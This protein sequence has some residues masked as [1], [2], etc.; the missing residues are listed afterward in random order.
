MTDTDSSP[1]DAATDPL[2]QLIRAAGRRPSPSAA[3]YERV[4]LAA[5]LAWQMKVHS[6]RRRRLAWW[7][8]AASVA[9]AGVA[10]LTTLPWAPPAPVAELAM[11]RGPVER[12]AVDQAR[13]EPVAR[14]AKIAAGDRLRTAPDGG[15]V[16][17]VAG[18]VAIRVRGGTDCT[19]DDSMRVTLGGGTL[20]VD[21]GAGGAGAALEITTPHGVVRHVG[22]QYEVRAL[23]TE[24]R[25]RVR[26][27]RVRLDAGAATPH[28]T[29]AGEEL[30]VA[31]GGAVERRPIATDSD[32]WRW[33]EAL[34]PAI[35]LDGGSA[36]DALQWVARETGKRLV[37][38]D[39]NVELLARNAVIRGSSAGL[40][41]MQILEVVM[42]TSAGLDYRIGEGTLIIRR[43]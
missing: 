14:G 15:A 21:T 19:F 1:T 42:A 39:S 32:E 25:V 26:E 31:A 36:F 16:F 43:R 7:A 2:G 22:T 13:W 9:T 29:V 37:F 5:H 17:T 28:E 4:R 12:F 38:E 6:Q 3:E 24:L 33:A 10:V 40:E 35:E 11:L 34:A 27:G 8:L 30:R 23:T 20:Y 18:R 41:P